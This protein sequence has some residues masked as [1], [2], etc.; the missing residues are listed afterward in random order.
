MTNP[1]S[2]QPLAGPSN[3]ETTHAQ[4]LGDNGL[5]GDSVG[6]LLRQ[7]RDKAGLSLGDVA[8]RL[9]M[10]IKQVRALEENDFSSLP[11]GTF[12]R[13]FVRN[14]AKA[15]GVKPESA[16]ALLEKTHLSA[17]QLS[18]SSV[19]VPSQQNIGVPTPGGDTATPRARL[20]IVAVIA[21]LLLI[22]VWW[23]W[24][25]VRPYLAEGGRPK[26]DNT[27][28]TV[29]VPIAVAEQVPGATQRDVVVVPPSVNAI[30]EPTQ[31]ASTQTLAAPVPVLPTLAPAP[32]QAAAPKSA[33]ATAG[34]APPSAS[35]SAGKSDVGLTAQVPVMVGSGLLGLTFSGKSW[36]KVLDVNGTVVV[37]K[38]FKGGDTE[39]VTGKAPFAVIIGNALVTRLAYNGKEVDLAPHTRA[40]VARMTVK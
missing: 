36:V 10:G 13:G 1:D 32:A 11:T 23:W 7:A 18:A 30:P 8:S 39:E 29:S 9:R 19:I 40:S 26:M 25:Y 35:L 12:L 27:A 28:T 5:V 2:L 20:V 33:K 16:L 34:V 6:E 24:E 4:S 17:V 38:I 14:F 3:V 37:D 15:V 31:P 21:M 22:I